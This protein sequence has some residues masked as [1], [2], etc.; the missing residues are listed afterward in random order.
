MN[1]IF[2]TFW[3]LISLD[4]YASPPAKAIELTSE[5]MEKLG[6][7]FELRAQG[8]ENYIRLV[9]PLSIDSYWVP[10]TTQVY[11][12]DKNDNGTLSKVELGSPTEKV[13]INVFYKPTSQD[14]MI[15][16]YYL[17]NLDRA[18]C[19]GDWDSRLYIIKSV[20]KYLI[21]KPSN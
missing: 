7:K 1:R 11:S 21:T 19:R 2:L 4:S 5:N 8:N 18:P 3:L 14:L 17:C 6:F 9:A 13:S 12:Y 16:V 15:G 10:V 20:E